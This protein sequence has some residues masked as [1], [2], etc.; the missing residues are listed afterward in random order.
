MGVWARR[1]AVAAALDRLVLEA[2]F[3][4]KAWD[5]ASVAADEVLVVDGR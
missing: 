3:A 1:A 2:L 5:A 4:R